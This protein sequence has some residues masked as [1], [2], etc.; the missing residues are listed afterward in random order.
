MDPTPGEFDLNADPATQL[1]LLEV[2]AQDTRL[3]QITHQAK[4]LPDAK[5]LGDLDARL[6]RLRDEVVASE[7]IASDLERDQRKADL[8][9]E[10]VRERAKRD[11]DL[12]DSG[13]IGDP[14]QLQSL[15][16]EL[17]SL[18]R[19]QSE[20]EDVEL[21]I[22]ERVEGA[23]AAADVLTADRDAVVA[24][25]AALAESVREQLATLDGERAAVA[26]TRADLAAGVP[27]ELLA[28]YDKI[29]A[30]HGGIGAAPLH[31]GRCEG[32]RLQ[33]P[34]TDIEAIRAAAPDAVLRCEECR[35]ILIRTPESG[36]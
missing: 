29:R 25:Q 16:H 30:D 31:K 33:L 32:C 17:E 8:D 1:R 15:Q 24:E 19:R 6:A 13:S 26:A 18:A 12:M 34:P 27:S 7:T 28:L 9:V 3:G 2:Q 20:L 21:E 23:R 14:K 5:R 35:R 36:L 4:N 22:M 11:R 10:Q